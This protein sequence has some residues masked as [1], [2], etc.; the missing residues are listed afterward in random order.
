VSAAV[1]RRPRIAVLDYEITEQSPSGSC[2]LRL[3][4]QLH[5]QVDFT[6]FANRFDNPAPSR[7]RFVPVRSLRRPAAAR[8]V[9]FFAAAS[10]LRRREGPFDLV[11]T[12]EGYVDS[13]DVSYVHFCHRAYLTRSGRANGLREHVRRLDHRLR[14]LGE[15]RAV[16]RP[17]LLVVPSE[18]ILSDLVAHHHVE[19][20]RIRVVTNPLDPSRW[21]VPTAYQREVQRRALGVGPDD[22]LVA[23]VALGHFERKGLPALLDAL[24]AGP[25]DVRLVVVGGTPDLVRRYRQRADGL[26]LSS[27]VTWTGM[28]EDIRPF[29][30]AADVLAMPSS[31]ETY[32]LVL[33]QGAAAGLPLL[34]TRIPGVTDAFESAGAGIFAP[35]TASDLAD[36]LKRI[37][38]LTPAQRD[39]MGRRGRVVAAGADVPTFGRRWRAVY[40]ELLGSGPGLGARDDAV[41]SSQAGR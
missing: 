18:G 2:H 33:H 21:V 24:A 29:V 41:L 19:P 11:Q 39:A 5:D 15:R 4:E 14:A 26:G 35:A 10:R 28:Q 16:A 32:S 1:A 37:R 25:A 40:D 6:V 3:L 12:V 20:S 27:R 13:C 38:M 7:I 22:L 17:R 23:F 31:Y 9:S 36:G 8:Y 34:A 30:W